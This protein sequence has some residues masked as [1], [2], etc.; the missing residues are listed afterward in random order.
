M[1]LASRLRDTS[2]GDLLAA[3]HRAGASG[4]LELIERHTR[5]A[6][7]LRRGHVQAVE[8]DARATR[9]GDV[10]IRAGAASR[11]CVERA[12]I[13]AQSRGLRI[14]QALVATRTIDTHELDSLLATQQRERL[15]SLYRLGDAEVRFRVARPLPEGA[16][17]RQP[18]G[19]QETFFGRPRRKP[20][21]MVRPAAALRAPRAILGV[22]ESA[23]RDEIRVAFRRLVLELHPDRAVDVPDAE[24]NARA[25]RL[26]EVLEAYRSLS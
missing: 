25:A 19:P 16:C 10:A 22:T 7:H 6:I 11:P 24:R 2:L 14:G 12:R 3:L 15:A 20:R 8:T 1:Q 23:N 17:E 26:V 9:L 13:Y 5:H 4:V 18:L 21:T